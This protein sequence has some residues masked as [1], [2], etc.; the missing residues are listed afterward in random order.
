MAEPIFPDR[1]F[2]IDRAELC[3]SIARTFFDPLLRERMLEIA[4]RYEELA[5]N[6]EAH[7]PL[8]SIKVM[9]LEN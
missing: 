6:A 5:K 4:K 9:R 1:K 7:S 3:C 8:E 2:L